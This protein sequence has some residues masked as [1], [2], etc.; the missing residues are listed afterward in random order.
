MPET[1]EAAHLLDRDWRKGQNSA[2]DGILLRRD[3]HT[4]YDRRLLRLTDAGQVT[5]AEEVREYFGEFDGA[6]VV[7]S[8]T[9]GTASPRD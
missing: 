5:L 3:L 7:H 9:V 1:L 2:S 8:D 4:L 6:V